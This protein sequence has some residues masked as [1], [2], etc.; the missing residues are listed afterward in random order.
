MTKRAYHATKL[1]QSYLLDIRACLGT[2]S[3]PRMHAC[4]M[5]WQF[6]APT[7]HNISVGTVS[8]ASGI[9][10]VYL[11][12]NTVCPYHIAFEKTPQ[13]KSGV[14]SNR[15]G[16]WSSFSFSSS[17]PE[18]C[19][20]VHIFVLMENCFFLLKIF[21]FIFFL[22]Q[23]CEFLQHMK[24]DGTWVLISRPPRSP[25]SMSPWIFH[26]CFALSRSLL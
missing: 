6:T 19:R 16:K 25:T 23:K 12:V 17:A 4:G 13:E 2:L 21:R 24:L 1:K 22:V 8:V 7:C 18:T 11:F 26:V 9:G 15:E 3:T 10:W 14:Q 20:Q 5:L